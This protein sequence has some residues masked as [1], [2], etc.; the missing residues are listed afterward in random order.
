M[1]YY[2]VYFESRGARII[3]GA[4]LNQDFRVYDNKSQED[5]ERKEVLDKIQ[6]FY[7]FK[8]GINHQNAQ[9]FQPL[10]TF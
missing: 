1:I 2:T 3:Q 9:L 7:L 6:F 5:V 10:S 4:R 8:K